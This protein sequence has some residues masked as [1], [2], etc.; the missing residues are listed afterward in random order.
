MQITVPKEIRQIIDNINSLGYEAYLIG[1]A[2]RDMILNIPSNDYDL[3]T[4]MPLDQVKE[5]LPGFKLM[6][7]NNHRNTGIIK[8]NSQEIEISSFHGKMP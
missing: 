2:V 6:K 1:G 8:I 3:C 5:L 4:N 7:E